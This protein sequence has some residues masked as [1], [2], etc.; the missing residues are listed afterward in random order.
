MTTGRPSLGIQG[1]TPIRISVSL[2]M[3]AALDTLVAATGEAKASHLRR[4]VARYLAEFGLQDDQ[5]PPLTPTSL[6]TPKENR[7]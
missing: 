1:G 3:G 5:Y 6:P 4:A 7:L 2:P